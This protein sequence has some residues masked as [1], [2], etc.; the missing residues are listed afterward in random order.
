ML[1][2]VARREESIPHLLAALERIAANADGVSPDY[3][4][5]MYALHLLA[6]FRESRALEPAV[7][8]A[9]SPLVDDLVGDTITE[10]LGAILAS[11]SGGDPRPIQELIEDD[12]ADEFARGA[13]LTALGAMYRAQML[14]REDFSAYLGHLLD[15]RLRRE[16]THVWDALIGVC[17]D[18]GMPEHLDAIR[19]AFEEGLADPGYEALSSVEKRLHTGDVKDFDLEPYRL[20]D[21]T[22]AEMS[23][24]DCF[25]EKAAEEE[26]WDEDRDDF[27]LP[28]PSNR[29]DPLPVQRSGPKVGRN[30]PCP[31]GSGKKYKKCCSG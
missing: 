19:A 28:L 3:M 15:S 26:L 27:V 1:E 14:S 5:H 31:C 12:A 21:D 23:W 7:R 22:I 24:W 13:G 9:R 10:G 4:L 30:A 6:Q 20:I 25:N 8:I 29:V 18:Q 11:V 17:T 2:A 16:P